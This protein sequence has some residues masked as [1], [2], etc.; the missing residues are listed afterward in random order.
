MLGYLLPNRTRF[1]RNQRCESAGLGSV[2]LAQAGGEPDYEI[3][4]NLEPFGEG[5]KFEFG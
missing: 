3:S 5:I 4:C 1:S 2:V